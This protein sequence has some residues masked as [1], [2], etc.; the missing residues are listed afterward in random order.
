MGERKSLSRAA[1]F[2]VFKRDHFK[3]QYCGS[4][5]PEV[6]LNVDHIHPVAEGGDDDYTNLITACFDCNSGKGKKLISDSTAIAKQ[7]QNLEE[8]ATRRDQMDMI[9]AWR[10]G[11]RD[12]EETQV[13]MVDCQ[14][15]EINSSWGLTGYGR[16]NAKGIIRKYGLLEVLEAVDIFSNHPEVKMKG[17]FPYLYGICRKRAAQK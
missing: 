8:M 10:E 15:R 1:R 12:M 5:A 9:I 17:L 4:M 11:M 7:R 13:D 2:E 3:C 6:V 16:R 14:L